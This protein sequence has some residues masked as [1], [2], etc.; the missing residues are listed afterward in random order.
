MAIINFTVNFDLFTSG[1]DSDDAGA[2]LDLVPL[3]GDVTF[4]PVLPT[5]KPALAPSYSPRPTGFMPREF[6]GYL[7]S[8]GRLKTAAGGT[9]GVRL[10]ANDPVL[11]LDELRYK[12]DFAVTTPTGESVTVEGGYITA[13]STDT[14]VNLA[15]A[16]S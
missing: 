4:T 15:S 11:N 7:D 3:M 12:V 2:D 6:V 9:V 10:W 13:P 8:D 5:R 1:N 16:M 14:T